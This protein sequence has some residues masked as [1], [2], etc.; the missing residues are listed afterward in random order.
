MKRLLDRI[1][2]RNI[3]IVFLCITVIIMA[4]GFSILS[5]QLKKED[6]YYKVSFT[7]IEQTSSVKGGNANP[8]G[9]YKINTFD[10]RVD[11]KFVLNNPYDELIYKITIRNEGNIPVE[12]KDIIEIP[13]YTKNDELTKSLE[14]IRISYND[15]TENVLE[16]DEETEINLVVQ[17]NPGNPQKKEVNFSL[18]LITSSPNNK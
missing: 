11:F 1:N 10:Q 2:I 7:S 12:I 16:P 5:I 14:P 18:V 15:I 3:V 13:E 17:F 6:P 4:I 9:K 8:I